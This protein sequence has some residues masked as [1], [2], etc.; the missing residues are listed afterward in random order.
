MKRSSTTRRA[1]TLIELLVVMGII[2]ILIALLFPAVKAARLAALRAEAEHGVKSIETA[3]KQYHM[4]YG[5]YPLQTTAVDTPTLYNTSAN[6]DRLINALRG[7]SSPA[8]AIQDNP[9]RMIYLEIPDRKLVNNRYLDPWE[10]QYQ[11]YVDFDQ[12]NQL[13][14]GGYGTLRGRNMAIWSMGEDKLSTTV[15]NRQDD[16]VSW[17][18]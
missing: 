1:F 2:G 18:K 11:I 4:D 17:G 8:Q 12:N 6:Y 16:I 14:A 5:R 3:I 9:K 15:S 10:Q 7:L 13:T